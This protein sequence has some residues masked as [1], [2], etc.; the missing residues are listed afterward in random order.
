MLTVAMAEEYYITIYTILIYIHSCVVIA[1][2]FCTP[3]EMQ[4]PKGQRQTHYT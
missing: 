1:Y 2:C 3:R 4:N